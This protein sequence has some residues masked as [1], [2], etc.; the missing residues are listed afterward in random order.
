MTTVSPFILSASCRILPKIAWCPKCT[1]S[2]VPMV[3]TGLFTGLKSLIQLY[4]SNSLSFVFLRVS[5]CL[6][7][8]A[9]CNSP[10]KGCTTK[11]HKGC[12]KFHKGLLIKFLPLKN[13]AICTALVAAPFLKLSATIHM[14]KV[15]SCEKSLLIRPTN[16]SFFPAAISGMG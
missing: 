8:V 11:G 7:R 6:L 13:S 12:T 1:P 4:I 5:L 3:T 16:T 2:K 10:V 15:F 14:F 9:L